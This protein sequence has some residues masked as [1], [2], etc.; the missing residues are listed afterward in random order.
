MTVATPEQARPLPISPDFTIEPGQ[1]LLL[2]GYEW[3]DYEAL[4]GF[5][6][7]RNSSARVTFMDNQIEIMSPPSYE[8]EHSKSVVGRLVETFCDENEIDYDI[9]GAT[10]KVIEKVRGAEPDECYFFDRTGSDQ[11]TPDLVIEVKITSG[12]LEKLEVWHPFAIPEVWIFENE[13]LRIFSYSEKEYQEVDQS[14]VLRGFPVPDLEEL[15]QI[16]PISKARREFRN[17]LT[18]KK[19]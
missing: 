19:G 2:E 11:E 5:F 3:E 6:D 18:K 1:R 15:C 9:A 14:I 4:V 12:G 16:K 10:R 7:D 8:H 17:R 13:H